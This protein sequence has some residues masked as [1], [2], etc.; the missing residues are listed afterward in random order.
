[1]CNRPPIFALSVVKM[2]PTFTRLIQAAN[3]LRGWKSAAQVARGLTASGLKTSEQTMTN[4]KS[5]GVSLEAMIDAAKIIGC[6]M[7]FI[8]D[9]SLPMKREKNGNVVAAVFSPDEELLLEGFR[10]ASAREKESML[11]VARLV[12]QDFHKRR[13]TN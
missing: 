13:E 10:L 3:E 8:R 7:E 6:R 5:R 9:G 2:H 11:Y 1:M 12:I 4:W